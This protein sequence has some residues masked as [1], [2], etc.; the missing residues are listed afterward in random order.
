M[1]RCTPKRYQ[2]VTQKYDKY[3]H[4]PCRNVGLTHYLMQKVYHYYCTPTHIVYIY[5]IYIYILYR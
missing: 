2:V 5:M 1:L 4:Y 3:M